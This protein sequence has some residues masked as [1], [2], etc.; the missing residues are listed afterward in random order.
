M[1]EGLIESLI[2]SYF[3]DYIENLDRNKLTIGIWSGTLQL[4]DI[5]ISKKV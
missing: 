3:G 1:F 5:I 2:L 4:E